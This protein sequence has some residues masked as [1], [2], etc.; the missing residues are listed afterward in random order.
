MKAPTKIEVPG[1][2]TLSLTGPQMVHKR[3]AAA[4][5]GALEA[6]RITASLEGLEIQAPGWTFL[7][8]P[9]PPDPAA[10]SWHEMFGAVTRDLFGGE[11]PPFNVRLGGLLI[12]PLA[13]RW[14]AE[15]AKARPHPGRPRRTRR[16]NA[17]REEFYARILQRRQEHGESLRDAIDSTAKLDPAHFRKAFGGRATPKRIEAA[18]QY[19]KRHARDL[20]TE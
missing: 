19:F 8:R 15:K 7:Y 1:F 4:I 16:W 18:A 10:A 11:L 3:V 9:I 17:P 14:A 20:A 5:G 6:Q 13:D 2:G 12:A